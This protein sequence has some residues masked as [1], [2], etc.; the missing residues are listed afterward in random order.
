MTRTVLA[1][2]VGV[3]IGGFALSDDEKAEVKRKVVSEKD[4]AERIDGKETKATVVEVT[5]EPGQ[6]S[7][8]HRHPGPVFGV[9][10]GGRVRARDQRRT[11]EGAEGRGDVLRTGRVPAPCGEEP[12]Q[13]EDPRPRDDLAP[14]RR[15]TDFRAREEVVADGRLVTEC[16]SGTSRAMPGGSS[17]GGSTPALRHNLCPGG[18]SASESCRPP[19]ANTPAAAGVRMGEQHSSSPRS[20]WTSP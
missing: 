19:T 14:A 5:L 11:R 17:L 12:R 13:G 4:I 1:V 2:A 8:A 6:E 16:E 7:A 20:I 3:A 10:P 15:E 9:R 18:A